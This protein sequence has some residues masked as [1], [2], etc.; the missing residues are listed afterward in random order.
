MQ[1]NKN[2]VGL[3]V[4]VVGLTLAAQAPGVLAQ[5][6]ENNRSEQSPISV[7]S[8]VISEA[9]AIEIAQGELSG[10]A[11]KSHLDMERGTP[12]WKVHIFSTDGSQFGFFRIDA[13]SGVIL[14]SAI[15]PIGIMHTK[16]GNVSERRG[17]HLG[18]RGHRFES[19]R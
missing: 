14:K 4:A 16:R 2:V 18:E 11:K 7:A 10:T 9:R 3:A 13:N 5:G 8:V 6:R 19:R 15:K 1:V 17:Q 12:T